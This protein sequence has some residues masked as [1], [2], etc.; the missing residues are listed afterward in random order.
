[1][2]RPV[3]RL[4]RLNQGSAP[5]V[6]PRHRAKVRRGTDDPHAVIGDVDQDGFQ[7]KAA[8]SCG[9][10]FPTGVL[11]NS[12]VVACPLGDQP[13]QPEQLLV[14]PFIGGVGCRC[15]I[16]KLVTRLHHKHVDVALGGHGPP[17]GGTKQG[18][19]KRRRVPLFDLLSDRIGKASAKLGQAEHVL[20]SEMLPV[21]N[22]R[23]GAASGCDMHDPLHHQP[24]ERAP[25]AGLGSTAHEPVNLRCGKGSVRTREHLEDIRVE[26]RGDDGERSCQVHLQNSTGIGTIL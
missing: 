15:L 7:R 19:S 24:L 14:P 8:V 26:R 18:E 13:A 12:S 6:R 3:R 10:H 2:Q 17:C 9:R 11:Q 4:R 23:I 16:F 22:V 1:M 25:N 21:Q 5:S 20:G